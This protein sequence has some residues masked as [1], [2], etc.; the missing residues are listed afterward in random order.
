MD[1]PQ[2][3]PAGLLE[4]SSRDGAILG[5]VGYMRSNWVLIVFTPDIS[6]YNPLPE[7]S[8]VEVRA[9]S[10]VFKAITNRPH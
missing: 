1:V 2:I 9:I 6:H 4:I 7:A 8:E 3:T 5:I 10:T